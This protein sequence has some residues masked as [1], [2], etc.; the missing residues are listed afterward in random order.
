MMP[1]FE[2]VALTA[3]LLAL[4]FEREPLFWIQTRVVFMFEALQTYSGSVLRFCSFW[5]RLCSV[6]EYSFGTLV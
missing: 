6:C 2:T 1:I 4:E 3:F 5:L